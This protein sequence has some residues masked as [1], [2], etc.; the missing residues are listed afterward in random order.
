M[1]I[2]IINKTISKKIMGDMEEKLKSVKTNN[3]T[4]VIAAKTAMNINLNLINPSKLSPL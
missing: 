3:K 2:T 4:R 1:L